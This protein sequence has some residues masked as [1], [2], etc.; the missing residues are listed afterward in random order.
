MRDFRHIILSENNKKTKMGAI[1]QN[2][3]LGAKVVYVEEG[4]Q[5]GM[6]RGSCDYSGGPK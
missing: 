3:V 4:Q 2:A 5:P 6:T 1:V